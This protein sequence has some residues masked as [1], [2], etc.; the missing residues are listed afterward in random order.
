MKYILHRVVQYKKRYYKLMTYP[1]LFEEYPLVIECSAIDCKK[2]TGV[3]QE[4][5]P[6]IENLVQK[7]S[8]I[9]EQKKKKRV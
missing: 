1:T 3:I 7:R 2:L 6:N 8:Q 9:I 5:F 4:Y